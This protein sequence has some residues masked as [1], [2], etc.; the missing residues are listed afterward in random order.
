MNY[1]NW[2]LLLLVGVSLASTA[3]T[4]FRFR[5]VAKL[6]PWLLRHVVGNLLLALGL[7]AAVFFEVRFF[8]DVAIVAAIFAMWLWGN[9]KL[10]EAIRN[11][12]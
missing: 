5:R 8:Y 11:N 3:A 7:G 6:R 9:R 4:W 2:I 1:G 12:Q 10:R